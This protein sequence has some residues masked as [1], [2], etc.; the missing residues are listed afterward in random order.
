MKTGDIVRDGKGRTYQLGQLLGRGLWGKSYLVR[1]DSD[2]THHVLKCAL[3]PGDFRG[4]VP[5]AVY[6]VCR[7]A[8]LEQARAY[9][10][11]LVPFLPRLEERVTLPDGAPSY[12]IPRYAVSLERRFAEGLPVASLID[13][14]LAVA[15]VVRQLGPVTG[16]AA[17]HGALRPSDILF[18]E[19]GDVVLTDLATPAVR[20]AMAR[21]AAAA[22]GQPYLAPELI[23]ASSEGVASAS[24]DSYALAMMLWRGVGAADDGPPA[25]PRAGLPKAAQVE[26]KDRLLERLK[27]EDSNPR[28][29]ARFAARTAV[30]LSRALSRETSPSP[31]FRFPRIE[32]FTTR[33]EEA[34]ALIRPTITSLG[35]VL[36][37]RPA[38]KPW[39]MTD[40]D[41]SFSC[42]VGSTPGV[43]GQEEIGVGIALFEVDREQRIK[44][45]DLGYTVDKHP[46]GRYRFAFRLGA[47]APGRYRAR[48]A[49]AVRDSGQPPQTSESEFMVRAAPGWVPR[50]EAPA[51]A[52][53][54]IPEQA[55]GVESAPPT[56]PFADFTVTPVAAP[57]PEARGEVVRLEDRWGSRAAPEPS[58]RPQGRL[59]EPPARS[60]G[61]AAELESLRA[62][63]PRPEQAREATL[64]GEP[65]RPPAASWP[66][67]GPLRAPQSGSAAELPSPSEERPY[68][69]PRTPAGRPTDA[70]PF[71]PRALDLPA[72]PVPAPATVEVEDVPSWPG[73]PSM[74]PSPTAV[75]IGPAP[76]PPAEPD[77]ALR[78][79]GGGTIVPPPRLTRAPAD[80][81]PVPVRPSEPDLV[82]TPPRP[83]APPPPP[84]EAVFETRN[85]THEPL[86]GARSGPRGR[87]LESEEPSY[88]EPAEPDDIDDGGPTFI[89]RA[90][91]QLRNDPYIAVMTGLGLM[92]AV[93]LV[94]FLLLR[95][96]S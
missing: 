53:L 83:A 58:T 54:H 57:P 74:G 27:L 96:G 59:T 25:Y 76:I 21:L 71:D 62:E 95:S 73:R 79:V 36:L 4:D 84:P 89:D 31:P 80:P 41:V 45:L 13:A 63:P 33:L 43:E 5:D 14:L 70:R 7:E 64:R 65:P 28:F 17:Q 86:P 8:L 48:L 20:R 88:V 78:P 93:L 9:E 32:E 91:E 39:F 2:D 46:S 60:A 75:P 49:F 68:E 52:P 56:N 47:L 10:Q 77:V 24:A 44:D 29:H 85:W 87:D 19:R 37:D 66:S 22:G 30:L 16:G 94:I 51:P 34:A 50:A 90:L 35:K 42:T 6:N 82:A 23:D 81:A 61:G 72:E 18:T 40:E 67:Q 69:R 11:G 3:G 1:R 55:R 92:I 15:R 12:I 26:L 38:S